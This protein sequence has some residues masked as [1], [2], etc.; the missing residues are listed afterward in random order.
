[1]TANR[2]I[3]RL[4]ANLSEQLRSSTMHPVL[5]RIYAHR[6]VQSPQQVEYALERLLPVDSLEGL[7]AAVAIL[8][9]ALQQQQHILIVGDFD[10]DGAT[11]SAL[12]IRALQWMGAAKVSY[13]VP[14]RFDFGYG[15]TPELVQ[16]ARDMKPDVLITVDS[17]ISC[18]NGV[19]AAIDAGITVVVTDHHLP[20]KILPVANAIVNPN[21]PGCRFESKNLAGVG[22]IFYTLLALRQR[23][24]RAGWFNDARPEPNM[25]KLLDL[26]ALGTVA[27]VVPLDDNNRILV[28]QGLKRI[29][30]GQCCAGIQALLKVAGRDVT[31]VAASDM[32]F[33]VGPRLNAAGRLE[34]MSLGIECLLTDDVSR[35]ETLARQL[36]SLNRNRRDIEQDMQQQA[37]A[38]LQPLLEQLGQ[39]QLPRGLCLY[40]ADWHQ[41]VI[42][43]LAARIKDK[44][45]RP[46]IA[47]ARGDKSGEVKGSAR[48]IRGLH[49][50]DALEN[51]AT[52]N[53]GLIIKFGGHAAAAGLSLTEQNWDAFRQAFE[54]E[55]SRLLKESDLIGVIESDG[56]LNADDFNLPLAEC[57]RAAGPWGQHFPE[58]MF[59][60]EF[61]I[62]D[63]KIVG[64]KHVKMQL[65]PMEAEEAL[66]AIAF[67]AD[68]EKLEQAGGYIRAAYKLDVNE[69]RNQRKVQLV[70]E[71]FEGL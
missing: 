8:H 22:V 6:G 36:D 43:I 25:A 55:C 9:T 27:D 44:F 67:N 45:N 49:I 29:R 17:G 56:E 24:R 59:D 15:L 10:A 50:R 68:M 70:I 31:N 35:A 3:E 30:A 21:Q 53:P 41:G 12:A 18:L 13:L 47:F 40:D 57:L 1:M 14:N 66:D 62:V 11:S 33:I 48:S 32:G 4:Q 28:E 54:T 61:E 63:W 52:Q 34:D 37:M 7:D 71:Y 42:G 58:P 38:S 19:K 16:V 69:F 23:L 46:V 20:G 65:L 39:S 64:E 51:I 2:R 5:Q 26:V 60:G